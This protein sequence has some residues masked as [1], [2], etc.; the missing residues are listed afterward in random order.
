[1]SCA[2]PTQWLQQ[3]LQPTPPRGHFAVW[4]ERPNKG[5]QGPEGD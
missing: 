3:W 4:A 1:M 5:P 2:A